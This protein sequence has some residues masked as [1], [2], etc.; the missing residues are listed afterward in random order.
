MASKWAPR[1]KSVEVAGVPLLIRAPTY[2]QAQ[3]VDNGGNPLDL[4]RACVSY[5][6]GTPWTE[7]DV[8]DAPVDVIEEIS[9]HIKAASRVEK[10]LKK[11]L[12]ETSTPAS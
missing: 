5:A 1:L 2:R 3:V 6:D 10:S 9:E 11:S 12:P 8:L 4:I 7:D